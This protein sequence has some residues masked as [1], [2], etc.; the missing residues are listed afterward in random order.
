[1]RRGRL[2]ARCARLV[3]A[4]VLAVLQRG[5]GAGRGGEIGGRTITT[6]T[7]A[8][9]PAHVSAV[10]ATAAAAT[11]RTVAVELTAAGRLVLVA[12]I[13]HQVTVGLLSAVRLLPE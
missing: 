8:S 6:P 7:A 12:H 13:N 4:A 3:A 2:A 9:I 5:G 1:M 10:I 11:S